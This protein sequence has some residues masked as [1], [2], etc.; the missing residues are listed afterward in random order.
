[1]TDH[2]F[3]NKGF[4]REEKKLM[5]NINDKFNE[6]TFDVQEI[7]ELSENPV[8]VSILLFKLAEE[9]RKTN[10]LLEELNKKY[11]SIMLELKTKGTSVGEAHQLTTEEDINV[12]PEQDQQ[13][14]NLVQD[15]GLTSA[16]EV[17][18]ALSYKG[19]NAASQRLNML[20][21]QGYLKKIQSG[22]KVLFL[23]VT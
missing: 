7:M 3:I 20:Y 23:P 12:L 6:F 13:I 4:S 5:E 18:K 14:L 10:Q 22:K 16:E 9:R 11:D 15:K 2:D 21:K 19:R 17:Q 1:M 8:F